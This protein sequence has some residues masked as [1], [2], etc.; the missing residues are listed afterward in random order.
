MVTEV[1]PLQSNE[2][3][4]ANA[5]YAEL[6]FQP[7]TANDPTFALKDE[8][9]LIALGRYQCHEDGTLELGGFWVDPARRGEGLARVMVQ[10]VLAALP[11]DQEAWCIA[12]THL[13]DFYCSFGMQPAELDSDMPE[14]IRAKLRF[15]SE[16]AERG[17]YHATVPLRLHT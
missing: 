13:A 12:F 6:A 11:R 5:I 16:Q 17:N 3:D 9:Q 10:R 8:E 7:S 2:L 1:G 14:S 15:C 4:A